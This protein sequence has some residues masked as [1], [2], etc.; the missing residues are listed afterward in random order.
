MA[1]EKPIPYK[2]VAA[3]WRKD[4]G[5]RKAYDALEP[6]YALYRSML[7][8]LTEAGI[9]QKEVAKRMGTSEAAVSRLFDVNGQHAPNWATIVKFAAAVGKRP[10]VTFVEAR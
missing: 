7:E 6:E 9:T 3:Q 8:S 2:K 1:K 5:Y 4:P 10:V